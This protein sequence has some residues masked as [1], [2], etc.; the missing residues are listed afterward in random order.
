M[1]VRRKNRLFD[2][3]SLSDYEK[4]NFS[5]LEFIR[6][7]GPIT[8]ADISKITDLNIVTVS[9]YI[10]TYIDQG[11]V[12]EGGMEASS[13]GRKPTLVKLN[14]EHGYAIGLDLGHT[15][16]GG[17]TMIGM[18]TDLSGKIIVRVER[19]RVKDKMDKIVE[20]SIEMIEEM[21]KKKDVKK[22]KV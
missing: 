13:G 12:I 6:R 3:H 8:R 10:N 16:A 11:L 7:N 19:H 22:D 18:V 15:G 20:H 5:I 2:T 14:E 9:N 21:L 4:R 17:A 1:T